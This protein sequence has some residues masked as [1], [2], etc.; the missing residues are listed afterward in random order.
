MI[1][2]ELQFVACEIAEFV[3]EPNK[4]GFWIGQIKKIGKQRA[5]EI[6]S[7]IRQK[8][9]GYL[10]LPVD[11]RPPPIKNRPAYFLWKAHN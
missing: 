11:K 9:Q 5:Y 2:S 10:Y 1:N 8:E 6:L 4:V 3:G 7:E